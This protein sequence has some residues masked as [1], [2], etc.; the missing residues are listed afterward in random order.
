MFLRGFY[1]FLV[2]DILLAQIMSHLHRLYQFL[3]RFGL[4]GPL[5]EPHSAVDHQI[6]H[7]ATRS[8]L[9]EGIAHLP[10]NAKTEVVTESASEGLPL[11]GFTFGHFIHSLE[12]AT[13]SGGKDTS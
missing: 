13:L 8:M 9:I 4:A 1:L 11:Y 3:Y 10:I 6:P 2:L 7:P 5:D 12:F